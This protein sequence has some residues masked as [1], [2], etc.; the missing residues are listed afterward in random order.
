MAKLEFSL[1]LLMKIMSG[2]DYLKT[3]NKA[4][5]GKV[6]AT[7]IL[8]SIERKVKKL[9]NM[10]ESKDKEIEIWKFKKKLFSY[11]EIKD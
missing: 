3:L 2:E 6:F 8:K 4:T 11:C 9:S 5:S 7:K 1:E 10:P